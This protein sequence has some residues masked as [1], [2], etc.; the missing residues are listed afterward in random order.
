MKKN[1]KEGIAGYLFLL[2]WLVGFFGLTLIPMIAS[3]YFSF[4]QYDMLTPAIPVGLKNYESLF[5]DGRFINSLKV[6]FKYVIVSVPLQL[7]FALLVA[8]MLKKNR[9]GVKVYRAMYYLPSLFGGSVAVSI[10]WRQLFNKEGVFNQILAVFGIEGKNWI[11]TPSSALNTLIVLAVWQFGASMVIFLASL[12]QIP[13]DYYEAA[14][15]D[16]AG[17][18]AQFFKITL[19]LLTPMVFFN[20]VM[21]VI[22]AFQSFNSAYIISNGSGGPLDSTLFYSLYL[23][24]KAFNH[25]QMGYASAMA[26]ILLLIIAAVTGLMFLFAKFWVFYDD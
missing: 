22:N 1:V 25:F 16:G 17:K 6:T 24:I 11:A 12:K 3:L 20:I 8:L 9:R 26:W 10:L 15:L 4:T 19:P 14:T 21:Q 23:Y 18:I 13:E 7:A 5:A 2:P